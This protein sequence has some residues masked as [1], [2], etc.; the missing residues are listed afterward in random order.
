LIITSIT[1]FPS[2]G[3]WNEVCYFNLVW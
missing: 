2:N 1:T 3:I